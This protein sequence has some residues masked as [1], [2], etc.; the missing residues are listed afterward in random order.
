M[1]IINKYRPQSSLIAAITF[2]SILFSTCKKYK[3]SNDMILITGT[4]T[5][6]LIK[7]TVENAPASINVTASAT[8]KVNQDITVNFYVDTALITSYNKKTKGNY[9]AAPEASY[10]I[11]GTTGVIHSGT[12]VSDPL[13]VTITATDSLLAGRSYVIPVTIKSVTGPLAVLESSRT[14]YLKIARVTHFNSIDLTNYNFYDSDTFPTPLANIS[15]FTFEVK[16]FINSWHTGNPPISRL[17]NWGPADQTTFNL[18][19]FGEAGSQQNQLQWINSSGGVFSNTLFALNTWYTISCTYDGS[20]CNLYVNGN[21]DNSFAA[22]GQLYTFGALELGMSYAGYQQAQ[23][24]LGRTAEIRFWNRPLSQT[25]IQQNLCGVDPSASGLIAYWPL[26][27]GS[28]QTF[29]DLTGNGRNMVWKK[30]AVV[31][32]ADSVNKCA[33]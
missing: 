25:E 6:N 16:C 29:Y 5:S 4:E 3:V 2:A 17:C 21:L 18:L 27:E 10:T 24:F 30:A 9:Y 22:T 28:G 31:W 32:N 8:G 13:K 15:A 12:N 33:Q 14:V 20:I 23:R 11:S 1:N 19:R 26:N 7:F